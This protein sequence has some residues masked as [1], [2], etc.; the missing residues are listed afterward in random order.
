[1]R[2]AR[3]ALAAAILSAG[4]LVTGSASAIVLGQ[5]DDFE[6][7]TSQGWMINLLGLGGAAAQPQNQASG[8]PGGAGDNFLQLTST[9]GAGPGSRLVAINVGQWTGN[10]AAAGVGGIAF[11]ARNLGSSDL[12]LR[13]Y[14]ENPRNAPPTDEAMT[15]P[16][17]LPSGGAWTRVELSLA[18]AD[19]TVLS[20]DLATLLAD[21]T[22]LRILHSPG[23]SFPGPAIAAT[24]GIDN[25][26]ALAAV[27]VPAPGGFA[28]LAFG[29]ASLGLGRRQG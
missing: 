21:V 9:G 14:L 11:D 23:T 29:L 7:G 10:Y 1:M 15:A 19:L 18:P 3:T 20:G 16:F 6:D 22:A 24:L 27:P 12:A 8:G 4:F 13:L 26:T 25:V 5:L 17:L 28:L 2:I